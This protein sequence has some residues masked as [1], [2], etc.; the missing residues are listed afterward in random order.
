MI[1]G[2]ETLQGINDHILQAQSQIESAGHRMDEL[3]SRLNTLRFEVAEQYR[4]LAKFRLDELHASRMISRLDRANQA[5]MAFLDK[6]SQVL[7]ELQNKLKECI[8]REQEL[9]QKRMVH[10]DA[11]DKAIETLQR[12]IESSKAR[13]EQT[14][15]YQRRKEK[16]AL[17]TQ[18]AQRADE[19]AFQSEDDLASKGKPY[20]DDSIFMYLWQR[21]YMTPEYRANRFIRSLDN[22]VARLIDFKDARANY[23]ML[24]K[25]PLRLREHATKAEE[26]AQWQKQ[27]L[28]A[29]EKE[30]AEKDGIFELQTELEKVEK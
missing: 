24:N 29:I 9:E 2:R 3:L 1:T 25:L 27:M 5:I 7:S 22:W 13:I 8:A 23:H 17:A 18:V 21:R 19:K 26:D 10:Q 6:R 12:Q 14:E 20:K 28:Q 16:V 30:A 4:Q 11:R 15:S